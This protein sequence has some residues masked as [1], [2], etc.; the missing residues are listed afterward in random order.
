MKRAESKLDLVDA[1]VQVDEDVDGG[2]DDFGGD[3][4]DDDP[5]EVLACG[6]RSRESACGSQ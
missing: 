4:D 3:E 5:F 2:D 6:R 1:G